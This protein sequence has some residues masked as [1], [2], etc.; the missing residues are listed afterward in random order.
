MAAVAVQ[1]GQQ[2]PSAAVVNCRLLWCLVCFWAGVV[3]L[4]VV[5]VASTAIAA[6]AASA[7]VTCSS[8]VRR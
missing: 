1:G 3:R 6:L 4:V 8:R 2:T 5:A 7:V